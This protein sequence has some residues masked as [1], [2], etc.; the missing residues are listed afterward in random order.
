MFNLT[1]MENKVNGPEY[2]KG[3]IFLPDT[4]KSALADTLLSLGP[5]ES[6]SGLHSIKTIVFT[7][8][9]PKSGKNCKNRVV[10]KN[11]QEHKTI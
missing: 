8:C 1:V 4:C 5:K 10:R 3:I 7:S 11:W 2:K 9:V 6:G